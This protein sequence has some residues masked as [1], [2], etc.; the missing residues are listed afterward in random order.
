MVEGEVAGMSSNWL[1]SIYQDALRLYGDSEEA[2]VAAAQAALESG[3]GKSAPG[4]NLFGI[5]S[6]N[7]R[8]I[9]T[10][11]TEVRNGQRV[12]ESATWETHG[13]PADSLQARMDFLRRNPRYGKAGYFDAPTA[14]EKAEA[15]QRAGY[16]TDPSYASK[17]KGIIQQIDS[18][19]P[20]AIDPRTASLNDVGAPAVDPNTL[21]SRGGLPPE[22]YVPPQALPPQTPLPPLLNDLMNNSGGPR[23][24]DRSGMLGSM[25]AG[26]LRNMNNPILQ[27]IAEGYTGSLDRQEKTRQ[28][29]LWQAQTQQA[30]LK[31][32]GFSTPS[33]AEVAR[34]REAPTTFVGPDGEQVIL[35]FDGMS[36][37]Y[38]DP[39]GRAVDI[40]ALTQAGYRK[41]TNPDLFADPQG[42]S[43]FSTRPKPTSGGGGGGR[44]NVDI[45][46]LDAA[47]SQVESLDQIMFGNP[48]T[49]TAGAFTTAE[50]EPY[51]DEW[52]AV[53]R[54]G[55]GVANA[56]NQ[57]NQGE[58][59]RSASQYQRQLAAIAGTLAKAFGDTG[60]LSE[61]DIRRAL[62]SMPQADVFPDSTAYAVEL[63]DNLLKVLQEKRAAIAANGGTLPPETR[64]TPPQRGALCDASYD[65]VM[66]M[67][68]ATAA[69]YVRQCGRK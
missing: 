15:L 7:G 33:A 10:G 44:G 68:D 53:G 40:N 60:T 21:P 31:Q 48:E 56:W 37:T 4:G 6:T 49:G 35:Y 26:I 45:D 52:G 25:G 39:N 5:K 62:G 16:A 19:A 65:E 46:K 36:G 67:D 24:D 38:Q 20:V 23:Q 59:N 2:K 47:I 22:M 13:S 54:L 64:E 27:G 42:R 1:N 66:A 32:Y 12:R 18:G 29:D 9:T 43:A 14:A 34:E 58:G 55:K 28:Q 69:E 41:V 57:L 61:G 11:T 8:G 50:G 17:L 3:Y 63:R 30:I 51:G